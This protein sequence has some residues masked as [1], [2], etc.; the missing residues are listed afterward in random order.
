MK[1]RFLLLTFFL[2]L[3]TWAQMV[4]DFEN[5]TLDSDTFWNG[6]SQPLGA[7]FQSGDFDFPNYYDTA[8][9]GFWSSGWAYSNVFDTITAGAGNLYASYP[10][11]GANNSS[12]YAVGQQNSVA[13][14]N[15]ASV[16]SVINGVYITNGTFAAIS[17]RDGDAF[18]KKFGGASGDDPDFFKLVIFKYQNGTLATDSVEFYLADYRF[19]DNSQDY[20]LD[21][22]E[23][24]DLSSLGAVDS[25]FFTLKSS[26]VGPFGIN[27]PTFFCID[28]LGAVGTG[29]QDFADE[30]TNWVY[31]TVVQTEININPEILN[32][33]MMDFVLSDIHG[34]EI[35]HKQIEDMADLRIMLPDVKPGV[36]IARVHAQGFIFST[37]ILR[38]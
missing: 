13:K 18:A 8:F 30:Q 37:K 6:V 9:G 34:R 27:T 23:W 2:P 4:A 36:Y 10:G 21:S 38:K 15:Q 5:L 17:M 7:S 22:W 29:I 14:L 19:S 25:L 1:Y 35:I 11:T 26:D 31:P 24:V 20:I 16:G 28:N 3:I 33:G 12:I 32:L